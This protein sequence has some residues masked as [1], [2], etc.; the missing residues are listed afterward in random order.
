MRATAASLAV[1]T[2]EE[3]GIRRTFGIPGVHNTELYDAVSR[4]NRI[5]PV[6]VTHEGGGAFMADAVS[7]TATDGEIGCLLIVP[8]AGF[9]HAAS[10]IGE[11]FLGGIPMLILTGGVRQDTRFGHKLHGVDQMELARGITKAAFRVT[12]QDQVVET[13]RR[14]HAIATTGLPGPVLVEIPVDLQLFD[15]PVPE[16]GPWSPPAPPPLPA[17]ADLDRAAAMLNGAA[18]IGIFA[19][20]GA[21]RA[22][23]DLI[24][25]A[26]ALQAPVATTLQGLAVMPGRHPLHVGFGF[27]PSAV[28]AAQAAF[29]GIDLLLTVGARFGEIPTGSFA[30]TPPPAH[31]HIDIDPDAIGLN[32]PA[33]PGLVGDAAAVLPAL[34]ERLAARPH[35]TAL[36]A[37]IAQAK[38][39][40]RA[41]WAQHDSRGR[42]NPALFFTALRRALPDDAITV[43]DDGNHT[44]LTAE[45]F[46]FGAGA[47]LLSPTDFNAMGYAVPA[48]IGAKLT[49]PDREVVAIVGDGCFTMTCMEL[50]TARAQ[51][52]GLVI[53]VFNDGALSQIA[54]AQKLPYGRQA[55]T[56]LPGLDVAGVAQAVGAAYITIDSAASI[57]PAIGQARQVAA[58]GRVAIVDIA[59]D[60]S[61][62]TA[63][64]KGTSAS[65][66]RGFAGRQKLRFLTRA[67]SRRIKG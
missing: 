43:L 5:R 7:R 39:D 10:G 31:I 35:D 66:F 56:D 42:V 3:L 21:R 22:T 55:C 11:A 16:A 59:I 44:F 62:P 58:A 41:A 29:A 27:G 36:W 9:T 64:T 23:P 33:D 14:A 47:T 49:A 34:L 53:F 2:L 17:A 25:L 6:L 38:D 18:R 67:L 57:A 60:Y 28:P 45:L 12:H 24:R 15:A 40:H 37:R 48:A 51:G 20:Y 65:T 46:T 63:F 19:G 30:I 32:Y 1:A 61:R 52:L 13:L 26:E 8:A 50:L 54:Q 4:S